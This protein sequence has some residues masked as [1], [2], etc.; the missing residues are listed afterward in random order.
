VSIIPY[1]SWPCFLFRVNRSHLSRTSC[2]Q[3]HKLLRLILFSFLLLPW[4]RQPFTLP[5]SVSPPEQGAITAALLG[6]LLCGLSSQCPVPSSFL[7]ANS[8]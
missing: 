7:C 3:N 1:S 2:H 8:S 5:R 6:T 4:K